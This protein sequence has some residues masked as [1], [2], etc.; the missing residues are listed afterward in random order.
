MASILEIILKGKDAGATAAVKGLDKALG[1]L[2]NILG[3]LG[4]GLG[5][6]EMVQ[7]G[8]ASIAAA[9]ESAAA[10]AELQAVLVSSGQA[11]AEYKA[12]LEGLATALENTSLFSDEAVMHAQAVLLT[13]DKIGQETMP[14][15]TQAAADLAQ[16][17]GT[18]LQSASIQIGKALQGQIS[19]LSRSGVSFTEEEK[20]RAE[21]LFATGRAAE[22]QAIVLAALEKQVGGQAAAAR[23]AAGGV[24][25]YAVAVGRLQEAMGALLLTIG[26]AGATD[27]ATGW[28]DRL[29]AGAGAW[30]SVIENIKLLSEANQQLAEES[31]KVE[32]A[33]RGAM[34]QV[35]GSEEAYANAESALSSLIGWFVE[36]ST[37]QDG[38]AKAVQEAASATNAAATVIGSTPAKLNPAQRAVK[39][40]ADSIRDL[41]AAQQ[42]NLNAPQT[43]READA[44]RQMAEGRIGMQDAVLQNEIDQNQRAADAKRAQEEEVQRDAEKAASAI[45]TS[46]TRAADTM[47]DRLTSAIENEIAPTLQEVWQPGEGEQRAD[48][49]ARRLATVATS[50]LGSEWTTQ[51]QQQ[52]GGQSFFQPVA[53]AIAGGDNAGAMEAARQVLI[54][55]VADLYDINLMAQR[56][57]EKLAQQD[58]KNRLIAEV[59]KAL[60]AE[61]VAA[62]VGM[63]GVA[64]GDVGIATA[65]TE[66]NVTTMAAT[67]EAAGIKVQ[68]A[69]AGALPAIDTLIARLNLMIGIIERVGVVSQNTAGSIAGLNPPSA[70]S[71][72]G[73]A[74]VP[75]GAMWKIGGVGMIE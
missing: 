10:E 20:A 33:Q 13:F 5:A 52:F 65:Q 16:L 11:T 39:A 48:E 42:A 53:D 34:G 75:N 54:N 24:Q 30:S 25:D 28:I 57:R 38:F 40:Y 41:T 60:G 3:G 15:A 73:A 37:E 51:L 67:T 43:G 7:F 32:I 12:Q 59:Q 64:A 63:V 68:T 56:V 21:A 44:Y 14:R 46:F 18:D 71:A 50:G 9:R 29:A 58:A 35:A 47:A 6:A 4:L 17:L 69:F 1:G 70:P 49:W 66:T 27:A 8:Q 31:G 61:G 26:D 19:A 2:R 55:N 72:P 62:S 23:D 45:E 22:A 36:G 74:A